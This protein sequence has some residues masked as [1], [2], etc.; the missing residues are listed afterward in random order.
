MNATHRFL[1]YLLLCLGCLLVPAIQTI[2]FLFWGTFEDREIAQQTDYT[3]GFEHY[4]LLVITTLVS[5]IVPVIILLSKIYTMAHKVPSWLKKT[6]CV[7]LLFYLL[8]W[9]FNIVIC[10]LIFLN[11]LRN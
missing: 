11:L 4:A 2:C 3:P 5:V 7:V 8:I 6:T 1:I 9:L 10:N